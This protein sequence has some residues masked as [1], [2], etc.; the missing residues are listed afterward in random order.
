MVTR[1]QIDLLVVLF[2]TS[3]LAAIQTFL[4]HAGGRNGNIKNLA[5]HSALN[6]PKRGFTSQDNVCS[7]SPLAIG[8]TSQRDETPVTAYEI[9][10]LHCIAH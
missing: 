6:P 3:E 5:H 1:V 2:L 10:Y 4:T 9:P 8:N 7:N